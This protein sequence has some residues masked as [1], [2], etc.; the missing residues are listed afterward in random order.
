MH[1]S[2]K[3]LPNILFALSV[4]LC[5]FIPGSIIPLFAGLPMPLFDFKIYAVILSLFFIITFSKNSF[6]FYL[7]IFLL[8]LLEA[9]NLHH[10]A[11]F[12]KT[13]SVSSFYK[14]IGE[15]EDILE[16]GISEFN[17]LWFI[18][19]ILLSVYISIIIFY[20]KFFDKFY[21][22]K[23]FPEIFFLILLTLSNLF[24]YYRN[25]AN[26]YVMPRPHKISLFNDTL[27]FFDVIH[28]T[29]I[30][31]KCHYQKY[32]VDKHETDI[33]N[34]IFIIGESL[35]SSHMSLFGYSH[36][37]TPFLDS[38]KNDKNFMYKKGI[39]AAVST[40]PST[41]LLLNPVRE[42]G[43]QDYIDEHII[44]LFRLAKNNGFKTSYLSAQPR[45]VTADIG[46]EYID[47][48]IF[49][50]E[51][52]LNAKNRIKSA[53]EELID[54]FKMKEFSGKNFIVLHQ[55][56]MHS[57]YSKG[58]EFRT[59]EFSVFQNHYDDSYIEQVTNQY[60]NAVLYDDFLFKEIIEYAKE[61]FK[62]SKTH[63]I[64]TSDHG[65]LL[66]EDGLFGH[67]ILH[68]Q[69]AQVPFLLYNIDK[70]SDNHAIEHIQHLHYITHY[71]ISMLI[72]RMLG[73][74]I[75]SPNNDEF[76]YIQDSNLY[77]NFQIIPYKFE[78][79]N[80]KYS[81]SKFLN[82]LSYCKVDH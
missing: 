82:E 40:K 64:I 71:D 36:P 74:D 45:S 58:Y 26:K 14:I 11:Y 69:V 39:S 67:S 61:R 59:K 42:P 65:E 3:F 44:N 81:K 43:F 47:E 72:A 6:I 57:P 60:D 10:L 41:I 66:G 68:P 1:R 76:H 31:N 15:I 70:I 28:S 7:L 25:Q 16:T 62:N 79:H 24:F 78:G 34:I 53:D 48:T 38:L 2:L 23:Y 63:I 29:N 49:S 27:L 12:H 18:L 52:L 5:L 56:H 55:R 13:I 51:S 50:N 22:I 8:F 33:D 32:T 80:I 20:K 17:R 46:F 21:K 77:G 75:Q 73:Y 19:P 30:R 9:I 35:S 37:T 54:I 4:A